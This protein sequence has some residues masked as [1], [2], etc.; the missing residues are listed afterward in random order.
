MLQK[1]GKDVGNLPA[2]VLAEYATRKS[3]LSSTDL[4]QVKLHIERVILSLPEKTIFSVATH[5]GGSWPDGHPLHPL[6]FA[7]K[8]ETVC[9]VFL[10]LFIREEILRPGE[11]LFQSA[12][13]DLVDPGGMERNC[14]WRVS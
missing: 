9:A 4:L 10:G 12:A 1:Y 3:R 2:R 8:D 14:Y 5:F 11:A 13:S 6:W 7:F